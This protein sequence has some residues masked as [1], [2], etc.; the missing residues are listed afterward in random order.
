MEA[1]S[2]CLLLLALSGALGPALAAPRTH[3]DTADTTDM[4]ET[5]F[6]LDGHLVPTHYQIT[7]TPDDETFQTYNGDLV[8]DMEVREEARKEA[9]EEAPKA[10]REETPMEVTWDARTII[11]HAGKELFGFTRFPIVEEVDVG[12]L[13]VRSHSHSPNDGQYTIRLDEPSL[14]KDHKYRIFIKFSGK[15]TSDNRGF[16]RVPLKDGANTKLLAMTQFAPVHARRAFPCFDEP[17]FQATF[18]L[19]I[20]H[21][22]R[23]VAR[24]TTPVSVTGPSGIGDGFVMTTFETTPVIS[25][26]SLSWVV[27]DLDCMGHEQD[28]VHTFHRDGSAVE[29]LHAASKALLKLL[30]EY[31]GQEGPADVYQ[32]V[33]PL[34]DRAEGSSLGM[35]AFREEAVLKHKQYKS[36][37]RL[38]G[39]LSVANALAQQWFGNVV[40]PSWWGHA[41]LAVGFSK[42]LEYTLVDKTLPELQMPE[43]F[44][45]MEMMPALAA[46]SRASAM[47]LTSDAINKNSEILAQMGILSSGKGAALL[48]MLRS[49]IT[50]ETFQKGVQYYISDM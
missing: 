23:F 25:P 50:E 15:L 6:R 33:V 45:V 36:P 43:R 27:T 35:V 30:Y 40:T 44:G 18:S 21:P 39:M 8:I 31:T 26:H 19:S 16:F 41:W 20:V 49:M 34:L 17:S 32:A 13:S 3:I 42:L 22:P 46:D 48:R 2:C 11:L 47:P 4:W 12:P 14:L 28:W 5:G 7:L 24:S 37:V 29:D 10:V 38:A 1:P 9:R